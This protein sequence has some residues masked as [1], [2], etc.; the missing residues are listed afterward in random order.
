VKLEQY[1]GVTAQ[2][3]DSEEVKTLWIFLLKMWGMCE[4]INS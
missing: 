1:R 3:C 4:W 2:D